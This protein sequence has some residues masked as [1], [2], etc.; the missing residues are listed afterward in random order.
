MKRIV[1][2]FIATTLLLSG[3]TNTRQN[4]PQKV[5]TEQST[6]SV[7]QEV[8]NTQLEQKYSIKVKSASQVQDESPH[9]V[10][11]QLEISNIS[12]QPYITNFSFNECQ[13]T[14]DRG[15]EYP[16]QMMTE[17]VLDKAIVAGASQK[18][19]IRSQANIAG[20]SDSS[21][22]FQKCS[23]QQDG[24]KQCSTPLSNIR[25]KQCKAYITSDNGQASNGW[26]NNPILVEF[27]TLLKR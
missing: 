21:R 19:T 18:M 4:I 27:P 3:C 1:L 11:Y 26:G 24:S 14:D 12:I 16:G 8:V 5:K 20:Y 23:Y 13:F 7:Q 22:G 9:D 10:T 6:G 2:I 25:I 17:T 15:I